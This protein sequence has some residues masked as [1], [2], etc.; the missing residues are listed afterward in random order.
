MEI[1]ISF[2][3]EQFEKAMKLVY[4]GNLIVN[5]I[6][7][8]DDDNPR[9]EEYDQ[10]ENI[11]LKAAYE[12][13]FKNFVEKEDGR[14]LPSAELEFD[15]EVNDLVDYYVEESF[16]AELSLR[17]AARDAEEEMGEQSDS[18]GLSE[19]DIKTLAKYVAEY[20]EEFEDY[21]I[22]NLRIVKKPE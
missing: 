3:K 18:E 21:G 14:F 17:L 12:N 16:W 19:E 9:I 6:R 2:S 13:G 8:G 7:E 20:N 15:E 22:D 5:S 11:F 4:I 1:K 10:L